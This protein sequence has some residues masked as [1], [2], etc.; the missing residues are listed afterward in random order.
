[1]WIAGAV[2]PLNCAASMVEPGGCSRIEQLRVTVAVED[3]EIVADRLW[4]QGAGAVE[5]VPVDEGSV[6]LRTVLHNV[7]LSNLLDGC[8]QGAHS[9][10][11][12][13]DATP[14][15]TWR[16]F[17]APVVLGD[18]VLCPAW[19]TPPEDAVGPVVLIEPGVS[20]GLGDHPTTMMAASAVFDEIV[21]GDEVADIG[22]G[23]GVLSVVAALRGA[24]VIATEIS[25]SAVVALHANLELNAVSDRVQVVTGS[26][27][28]GVLA[29]ASRDVVVAN[30]SA[31]VLRPMAGEL[32]NCVR[33]NGLIVATGMLADVDHGVDRALEAAGAEI[34]E[35]RRR[36]AWECL[37]ARRLRR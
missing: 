20:F 6:E 21:D 32:V 9:R 18:L 23:S 30:I 5:E 16:E 28:G 34:L 22:A 15:E 3:A 26:G 31:Q 4:V 27:T 2:S 24:R 33:P 17:A 19:C 11:V 10:L 36:D 7:D 8:A 13:I 12:E 25:P 1:M 14:A 37:V 35:R 29:A